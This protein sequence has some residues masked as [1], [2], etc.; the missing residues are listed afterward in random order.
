MDIKRDTKFIRIDLIVKDG[1]SRKKIEHHDCIMMF[2]GNYIIIVEDGDN[3]VET[4][5]SSTGTIYN[6]TEIEKYKTHAL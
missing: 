4:T 1:D 5:T 6:L 2:T 3:V